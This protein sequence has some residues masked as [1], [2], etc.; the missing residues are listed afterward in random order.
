M[1]FGQGSRRRAIFEFV[2]S[3]AADTRLKIR[4]MLLI[5]ALTTRPNGSFVSLFCPPRPFIFN[6]IGS[7]VPKKNGSMHFTQ[8]IENKE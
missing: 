3:D 1:S 6:E 7:F 5:S 2:A 8:S 4:S